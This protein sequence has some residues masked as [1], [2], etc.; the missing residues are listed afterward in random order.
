[1]S[2][3]VLVFASFV[4]KGDKVEAVKEILLGMRTSTRQEP[5]CAQYDL[6]TA[7]SDG[8]ATFHLI[9][10][11]DDAAALDFHRATEHYKAYRAVIADLL[12]EPIGVVVLS[13]VPE[14]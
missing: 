1:M 5:G 9:E 10:K 7:D 3:P 6:F 2:Q 8:R 13:E 14:S 12:D 11:Y 4:P